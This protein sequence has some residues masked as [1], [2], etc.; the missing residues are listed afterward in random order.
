MIY[1]VMARAN[2]GHPF[3]FGTYK[4]EKDAQAAVKQLESDP[5]T[6]MAWYYQA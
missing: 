2:D 6:Q 3:H 4:T 1:V 5:F